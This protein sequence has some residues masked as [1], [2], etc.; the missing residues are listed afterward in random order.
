[1][2]YLLD[3]HVFLWL[4][5]DSPE[6]SDRVREIIRD[7]DNEIYLSV[8]S[9][10]EILVKQRLGKLPLPRETDPAAF[11]RRE[12]VRHGIEILNLDEEAVGTLSRLP[13]YH[14]DPFDRMLICQA[15]SAA[16]ILLTPDAQIRRYPVRA[17]W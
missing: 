13:D 7:R 8:V 4:L 17:Q 12:R 15:I 1:M 3:T 9:V 5:L 11:L 16:M 10:W 6:L 2:N 14:R